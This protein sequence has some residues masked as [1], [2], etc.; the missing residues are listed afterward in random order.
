MH[1]KGKNRKKQITYKEWSVIRFAINLIFRDVILFLKDLLNFLPCSS[2][3][4]NYGSGRIVKLIK[5]NHKLAVRLF[6]NV[7]DWET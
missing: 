3:F 6:P 2:Q 7:T 4:N 5:L 1:K